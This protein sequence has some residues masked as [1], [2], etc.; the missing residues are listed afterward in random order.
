MA[1]L[2]AR[3]RRITHLPLLLATVAFACLALCAWSLPESLIAIPNYS[4]VQSIA[5]VC[6]SDSVLLP[7][8]LASSPLQHIVT[9]ISEVDA[10]ASAVHE[11]VMTADSQLGLTVSLNTQDDITDAELE[12]TTTSLATDSV[13][14]AVTLVQYIQSP[15]LYQSPSND[16]TL[17]LIASPTLQL[18]T[19]LDP[20]YSTPSD[21]PTCSIAPV[22]SSSIT[23]DAQVP[24]PSLQAPQLNNATL[25]MPRIRY[26]SP[27]PSKRRKCG[28]HMRPWAGMPNI[29]YHPGVNGTL[30]YWGPQGM[31][32]YDNMLMH[33]GDKNQFTSYGTMFINDTVVNGLHPYLFMG[34]GTI[35]DGWME[36]G[37]DTTALNKVLNVF[38]AAAAAHVA[39]AAVRAAVAAATVVIAVTAVVVIAAVAIA[40]IAAVIVAVASLAAAAAIRVTAN[41]VIVVASLAASNSVAGAERVVRA[42]E[43]VA[44]AERVARA[45]KAAAKERAVAAVRERVAAAKETTKVTAVKAVESKAVENKAVVAVVPVREATAD[46]KATSVPMET[47]PYMTADAARLLLLLLFLVCIKFLQLQ[48]ISLAT[49]LRSTR[50]L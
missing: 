13:S 43:K 50:L 23:A 20:L 18:Q 24:S 4:S 39:A 42:V 21:T 32:P 3:R 49:T 38:A 27:P 41:L 29:I 36:A 37:N 2:G 40:A 12:V 17:P 26:G 16:V 6:P 44:K 14:S 15:V 31:Y 33:Y 30:G 8:T 11:Q 35:L 1:H 48:C 5:E 9:S 19:P 46:A 25:A 10:S 28:R 34:N 7:S 47:D 45:A 22:A